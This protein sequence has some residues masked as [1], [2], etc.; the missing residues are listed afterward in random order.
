MP[1]KNTPPSATCRFAAG[2]DASPHE[3]RL[4]IVSRDRRERRPVGVEW[5]GIAPLAAGAVSGAHFVDRAAVAAALASLCARRPRRRAMRAM[6]W[7]MAIPGGAPGGETIESNR[8][9]EARVEVAAAA[10][11]ALAAVDNEPQAALRA[12]VH[13][14]GRAS[15]PCCRFAA[16]WAGY[17]GVHGW[18]VA[19]GAVRSSFRFP[20]GEHA[21]LESALR[22]LAGGERLD[23]AFV[24]GDLGLLEHV[25]LALADIGECLACSVAPFERASFRTGRAVLGLHADWRRTAAFAVAFGLA[26]RGVSE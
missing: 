22:I 24:G 9:L 4:V 20:G 12:L 15:R 10:G 21:D 26:L 17:D 6:P 16:V 3:V 19:E 8:H 5:I 11:I 14:A 18:R 25:G 2:I 1:M 7:A 13:A 23:R